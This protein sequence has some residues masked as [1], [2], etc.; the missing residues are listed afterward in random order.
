M[1]VL[2][3]PELKKLAMG[4]TFKVLKVEGL[5]GM[6]MPAHHSTLEAVIVVQQGEALLKMPDGEYILRA[7]DCFIVPAKKEHTLTITQDLEA[8]AIMGITSEINFI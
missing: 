6:K 8:L 2:H 3:K 4:N 7:G 5:K 1:D